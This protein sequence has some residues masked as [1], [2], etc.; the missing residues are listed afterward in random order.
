[1]T[2]K[3]SKKK[4]AAIAAV[5]GYIR[6]EE[7]AVMMLGQASPQ[8]KRPAMQPAVSVWG[9]CGR[10]DIMQQRAMMQI[11]AYHGYRPR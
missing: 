11:K 3:D 8:P 10:S 5:I 4:A 2:P 6:S 9:M 7:D 1:M